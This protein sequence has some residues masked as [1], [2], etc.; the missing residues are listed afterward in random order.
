LILV[1]W[2]E[3]ARELLKE[4]SANAILTGKTLGNFILN[5]TIISKQVHCIG[6]GLGK[7]FIL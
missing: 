3:G 7:S 5:A 2:A 6:Q 1:D 4:A